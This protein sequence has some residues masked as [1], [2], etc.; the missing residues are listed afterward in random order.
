MAFPSR[1][2]LCAAFEGFA[3]QAGRVVQEKNCGAG[4][5]ELR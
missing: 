4:L 1:P 2:A 5:L 3:I